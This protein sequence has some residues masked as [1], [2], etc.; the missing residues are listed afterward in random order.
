MT[1]MDAHKAARARGAAERGGPRRFGTLE[2][3]IF[4]KKGPLGRAYVLG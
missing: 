3:D 1:E 4:P 2:L